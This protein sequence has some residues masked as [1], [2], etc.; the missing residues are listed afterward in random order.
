M[1]SE[2]AKSKPDAPIALR[3]PEG[4]RKTLDAYARAH[5]LTRS[6]VVRKAIR[7]LLAHENAQ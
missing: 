5:D 4:E 3:L 2:Q 1:R 7:Q 6:Q